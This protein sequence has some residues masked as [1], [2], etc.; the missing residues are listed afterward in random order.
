MKAIRGDGIIDELD[1][2]DVV[3][4]RIRQL[5]NVAGFVASWYNVGYI[6]TDSVP[7][8]T[9]SCSRQPTDRHDRGAIYIF[10]ITP[11]QQT[12]DKIIQ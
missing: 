8:M 11:K 10:I 6:S 2:T 5:T 12:V 3:I 4:A 7:L 1:F 9:R